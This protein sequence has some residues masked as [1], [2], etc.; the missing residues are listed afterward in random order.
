[1]FSTNRRIECR[2][3]GFKKIGASRIQLRAVNCTLRDIT[4]ENQHLKR[5]EKLRSTKKVK[6]KSEQ[7]ETECARLEIE[8]LDLQSEEKSC[9]SDTSFQAADVESTF[10]D[11]GHRKYSPEIRKPYYSLLANQV[12]VSRITDIV[13]TVLKCF[14]PMNVEELRLPKKMH[15]SYMKKHTS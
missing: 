9:D 6:D 15:V 3:C 10:Q 1:M 11:I 4:N 7:L 13:R 2:N 5:S 12:P 14:N 8:N